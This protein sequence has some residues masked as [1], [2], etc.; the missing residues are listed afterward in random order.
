[1]RFSLL[2]LAAAVASAAPLPKPAVG[3]G[4]A[5]VT[6]IA[7][8]CA[9]QAAQCQKAG[10]ATKEFVA[11]AASGESGSRSRVSGD[12]WAGVSNTLSNTIGNNNLK[13]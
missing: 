2:I 3:A 4:A 13:K 5:V 6:G 7:V 10:D 9:F 1:M 11:D 12:W 8:T